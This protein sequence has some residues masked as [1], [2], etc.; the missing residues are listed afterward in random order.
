MKIYA[1]LVNQL[2]NEIL[3]SIIANNL[4]WTPWGGIKTSNSKF[5]FKKKDFKIKHIF[6]QLQSSLKPSVADMYIL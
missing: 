3:Q 6:K 2:L 1:V 4:N 5:K